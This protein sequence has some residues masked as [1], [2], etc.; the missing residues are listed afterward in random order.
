MPAKQKILSILDRARSAMEET[1]PAYE[2][3]IYEGAPAA[4]YDNYTYS[5]HAHS[6][7]PRTRY[8]AA[9]YDA[10]YRREYYREPPTYAGKH[11]PPL[12]KARHDVNYD[13][14]YYY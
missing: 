12:K 7:V 3:P 8:D 6:S 14:Y 4:H 10:E 2:E 11:V 5:Q 9:E 13:H 1:Y